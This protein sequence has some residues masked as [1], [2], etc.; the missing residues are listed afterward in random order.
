MGTGIKNH[1]VLA[2][3]AWLA[4][5]G[6]VAGLAVLVLPSAS[7]VAAPRPRGMTLAQASTALQAA[8]RST[9]SPA[10]GERLGT[11]V[12]ISGA[13]AV[14]GAPDFNGG[15]GAAEI[16][17]RT[18]TTWRRQATLYDRRGR[19]NDNFGSA[20][21][22]SST[23][24]GTYALIA[25]QGQGRPDRAFVYERS[26]RS[27]HLQAALAGPTGYYAGGWEFGW[28]VAISGTTALVSTIQNQ[29][30][31]AGGIYVFVRSGTTWHRQAILYDPDTTGEGNFGGSVAVSGS[32]IMAGAPDQGCAFV[33][34][35]SGQDWALQA[36]LDTSGE[37]TAC[38]FGVG[39][40]LG[41]SV[42]VS[43]STAVIG[44]DGL[45][46]DS[47]RGVAFVFTRSGT[48][49]TRH[50]RLTDPHGV[51]GDNFGWSVAFSGTRILVGA[52]F[53]AARHC[54]TAYEYTRSGTT[55]RERAEVIN[56]GCSEDDAFGSAL[57]IS[58]ATAMIGSP[59]QHDGTG[60]VYQQVLP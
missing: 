54:G 3:P 12:A 33:F 1:N 9:T 25:A 46:G 39:D 29:L 49:W 26:G 18:G 22:V 38:P 11:S 19:A 30:N 48:T 56:P 17:V 44:A 50:T 57:A 10:T 4:L 45:P 34:A 51:N 6:L 36:T 42:A 52:P 8:I 55:W 20:V 28:S 60:A 58:G 43:G 5:A 59:G 13:T 40:G 15:R 41:S 32:T 47:G 7:A 27:W 24:A 37:V 23:A 2:A 53:K 35:R 21:A 31:G 14:V 16:F